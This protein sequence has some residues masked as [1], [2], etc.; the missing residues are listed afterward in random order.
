MIY[1][2][3]LPGLYDSKMFIVDIAISVT[4]QVQN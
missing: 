1:T 2:T 3:L 4:V